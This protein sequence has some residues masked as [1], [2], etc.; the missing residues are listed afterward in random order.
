MAKVSVKETVQ[1]QFG[2]VAAEYATSLVHASGPD[3][4]A[5]LAAAPL[6]GVERVLDVGC[7][8]GHTALAFAPRVASV[9]AVDLTAAMLD[10]GRRLAA[11]RAVANVTFQRGDVED[12]SCADGLFDLVTSRYSAHHYPHPQ[13]ALREIGRVLRPGGALL[14]VDV[15]A[16]TDASADAS[17]DAFLNTIETLRDPSHVRDHTADEWR[18]MMTAARL[19]PEALGTWPLR[20]RFDSWVARMRTPAASV[21]RIK[22]LLDGASPAIRAA[23]SVEDDYSFTVPVALIRGTLVEGG[24]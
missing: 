1:R 23:L 22:G 10:E 21:M 15:V 16:P 19:A 17:A 2:P 4:A 7:G 14:L 20:L 9:V 6:R 11:E 24:A 12:L 5:M 8:A 13:R 3:L 18:G